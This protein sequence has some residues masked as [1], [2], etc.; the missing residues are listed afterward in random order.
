MI[1]WNIPLVTCIF[2]GIHVHIHLKTRVYTQ[3]IHVIC[4]IFHSIPLKSIAL[5]NT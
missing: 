4:G 1:T 5:T 2:F 3:K